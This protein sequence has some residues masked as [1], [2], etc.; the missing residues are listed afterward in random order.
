MISAVSPG[1]VGFGQGIAAIEGA[2]PIP[3]PPDVAVAVGDDVHAAGF[4]PVDVPGEVVPVVSL[5]LVV[6]LARVP[7]DAGAAPPPPVLAPALD[8]PANANAAKLGSI[9]WATRKKSLSSACGVS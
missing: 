3:A 4:E 8:A 5:G 2:P 7:A 6:P 1:T 9:R